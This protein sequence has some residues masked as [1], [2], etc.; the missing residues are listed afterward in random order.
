MPAHLTYYVA[1]YK[2]VNQEKVTV[3]NGMVSRFISMK[4]ALIQWS[5]KRSNDFLSLMAVASPHMLFF[6]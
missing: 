3:T 4:E 5:L 2:D 6:S 1:C